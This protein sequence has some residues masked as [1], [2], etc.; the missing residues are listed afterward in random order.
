MIRRAIGTTLAGLCAL[1]GPMAVGALAD[2]APALTL[3][4]NSIRP[5]IPFTLNAATG[6]PS[7][8]G[9]QTVEL[10]FTDSAGLIFPLDAIETDDDGSWSDASVQLPVAG[11]DDSG[12]WQANG[13]ATGAGTLSASCVTSGSDDPADDSGDSA[14]DSGDSADADDPG[15][16]SGDS[17]DPGDDNSDG[18]TTQS[19]ADAAV[20]V[21][22]VAPQ[23][24]VSAVSAG[25]TVTATPGE[26]CSGTG[27]ADVDLAVVQVGSAGDSSDD[28]DDVS[29]GPLVTVPTITTTAGGSWAP[30]TI[31]LPSGTVGDFAVTATCSRDDSVTS[32]YDAEP[33]ALGTVVLSKPV[34]ATTGAVAKVS[35]SY[36][37]GITSSGKT[38]KKGVLALAGSGPWKVKLLS[39]ATGKVLLSQTLACAA[40]KYDLDVTRTSVTD[41]GQVRAR[42]CNTGTGTATALLQVVKGKLADTVDNDSLSP[43]ECTWLQGGKVKPG[44][45]AKA[46]VLL[47]PPGKGAADATVAEKFTVHRAKH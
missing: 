33:L 30:V 9:T 1:T 6:C 27:A 17:T 10:S 29:D 21:S 20:T 23:F 25:N 16:D 46:Q 18:V 22:G 4:T 38:V 2:T 31:T 26:A 35:G 45:D 5:G 43:G 15:D 42:V 34:C 39:A 11:V 19:Y 13:A 12:S 47:D 8:Q 24:T 3:S 37:G 28:G 32:S 44:S 7:D 14:D 36:P 40:V 41:N